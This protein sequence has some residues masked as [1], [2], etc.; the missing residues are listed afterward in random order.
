MLHLCLLVP[1]AHYVQCELY[2]VFEQVF[3]W[4]L[5]FWTKWALDEGQINPQQQSFV[6]NLLKKLFEM[7]ISSTTLRRG[8]EFACGRMYARSTIATTA[9]PMK[10]TNPANWS[11]RDIACWSRFWSVDRLYNRLK[12]VLE[13][14]ASATAKKFCCLWFSKAASPPCSNN[15]LQISTCLQWAKKH[16]YVQ[17]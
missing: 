16:W 2:L 15:H 8:N 9:K 11:L 10:K 12:T 4:F 5:V 14:L 7:T 13:H 1:L 3:F 6:H 17:N